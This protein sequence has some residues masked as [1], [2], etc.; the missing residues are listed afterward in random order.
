MDRWGAQL[1]KGVVELAV[2][3]SIARGETYGYEIVEHLRG[4]AGLELTESTVYPVLTRLANDRL[5]AIRTEPSPAGPSRRYYRLTEAG[6]RRFH[7]LSESWGQ[8]SGS[9][10]RLLEGARQ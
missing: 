2:F 5:L 9:L 7:E 8:I 4:Y 10:S 3:A 6:K 1:R